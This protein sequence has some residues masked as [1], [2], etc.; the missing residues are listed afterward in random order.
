MYAG[1]L[2]PVAFATILTRSL[3]HGGSA[4]ATI[5]IATLCLFVFAGIGFV[6]GQLAE[7]IVIDSVRSRFD[8]ELETREAAEAESDAKPTS[9]A[10]TSV[11]R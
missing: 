8:A 3:I 4:D 5:K 2:G 7:R 9:T 1:I 6:A 11:P 10:A